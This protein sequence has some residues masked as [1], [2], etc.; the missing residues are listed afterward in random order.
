MGLTRMLV[1]GSKPFAQHLLRSF[2]FADYQDSKGKVCLS[3]CAM[4]ET[5]LITTTLQIIE[6]I[7][8]KADQIS[9]N[10]IAV[11]NDCF[12][13][14][15]KV[16]SE[17]IKKDTLVQSQ[18]VKQIMM[19]ALLPHSDTKLIMNVASALHQLCTLGNNANWQVIDSVCSEHTIISLNEINRCLLKTKATYEAIKSGGSADA[20]ME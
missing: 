7:E 5:D 8:S 14:I 10:L 12:K 3:E 19:I 9:R 1:I 11:I 17:L 15:E 4:P 18:T 20:I 13:D 6:K 2:L 16:F